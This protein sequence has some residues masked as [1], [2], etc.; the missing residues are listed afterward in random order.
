MAASKHQAIR[1]AIAAL[2]LGAPQPAASRVYENRDLA[3]PQGVASHIQVFLTNTDPP[4]PQL[5]YTS[6][7]IDWK[8]QLRTVIKTRLDGTTSADAAADAI[9]QVC[10]ARVMA[11]RSLGG[12]VASLDTGPIT[13]EQDEVDN[14]VVMVSWD[15][16]AQHRTDS[17]S[18]S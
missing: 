13:W 15:L 4:D 10:Y 17:N 12:L 9:L 6:H 14:T 2:Y 1:N 3:L 18:I 5:V 11:N 7:P 16:S 8:T